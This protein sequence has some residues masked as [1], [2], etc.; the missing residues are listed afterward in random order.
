MIGFYD[1][2]LVKCTANKIECF[3]A[4]FRL[5]KYIE[6]V[7]RSWENRRSQV[8]C[9]KMRSPTPFRR[10]AKSPER[11]IDGCLA[12]GFIMKLSWKLTFLKNFMGTIFVILDD[13]RNI[14]VKVHLLRWIDLKLWL[15]YQ[16]R[17]RDFLWLLNETWWFKWL[18]QAWCW[19][20]WF[21]NLSWKK[22]EKA[23]V[24]LVLEKIAHTYQALVGEQF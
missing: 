10:Q 15:W 11:L 22:E 13:I 24:G 17:R 18:T 21:G 9:L 7:R 3:L 5:V 2:D 8:F 19:S 6:R 4:L 1:E 23:F 20:E 16:L 14:I 12:F